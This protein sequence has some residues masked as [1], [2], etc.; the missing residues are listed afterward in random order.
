MNCRN[1]KGNFQFYNRLASNTTFALCLAVTI[2]LASLAFLVTPKISYAEPDFSQPPE[3]S[4]AAAILI[5]ANTGQVLFEKEADAQRE[6]ASTTK[7]MTALLAIEALSPET[8]VSID[9]EVEAVGESQ[10]FLVEGEEISVRDLL[11]G[12][13]ITSANDAAVALAKTVAGTEADFVALMNERAA[14]LGLSGTSFANANGLEAENHY[15]T[16]RDMAKLGLEAMKNS[17]FREYVGT[18][19]YTIPA[20]N[21]SGER[22]MENSNQMLFD[23]GAKVTVYDESRPIKYDGTIGI[24]TGFTDTAGRCLVAMVERGTDAYIAVVLGAEGYSTKVFEDAITLFEYGFGN[25]VQ[26]TAFGDENS[27]TT[28]AVS[29]GRPKKVTVEPAHEV[30]FKIPRG[31]TTEVTYQFELPESLE[32]PIEKGTSVGKVHAYS[33]SEMLGSVDMITSETI[34]KGFSLFGGGSSEEKPA[35]ATGDTGD[36][37]E[38]SSSVSIV[39]KILIVIIVLVVAFFF[40]IIIRHNKEVLARRRRRRMRWDSSK[41][42]KTREIKRVKRIK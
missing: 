36:T 21:M 10:I 38:K 20:T 40:Y 19:E 24:K 4:A 7:I 6:P 41:N 29:K 11:F 34:K 28:V 18:A 31:V 39:I 42:F 8:P 22:Y 3:I 12:T 23:E 37:G 15:S 30:L 25:F 5:D 17:S 16:A 32:G 13:L 26:F 1:V 2:F 14:Q 27:H 9:K 35:E 33:G